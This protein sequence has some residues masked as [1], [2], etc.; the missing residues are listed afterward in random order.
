MSICF[1]S[2]R[3]AFPFVSFQFFF[4]SSIP[5]FELS[6]VLKFVHKREIFNEDPFDHP[7]QLFRAFQRPT[8]FLQT[9][10]RLSSFHLSLFLQIFLV[11]SQNESQIPYHVLRALPWRL[12]GSLSTFLSLVQTTA[13]PMSAL[14]T[15]FSAASGHIFNAWNIL[16]RSFT[17]LL[18]FNHSASTQ[19]WPFWRGHP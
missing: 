18:H 4:L 10:Q 2:K 5:L 11:M 12:H 16:P 15:H 8:P 6:N 14:S 17:D 13:I 9:S 19:V 7:A 3:T 1:S